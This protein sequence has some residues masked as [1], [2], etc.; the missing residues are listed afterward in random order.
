MNG[1]EMML[2]VKYVNQLDNVYENQGFAVDGGK[3]GQIVAKDSLR[4]YRQL[5]DYHYN[6]SNLRSLVWDGLDV[7]WLSS[8]ARVTDVH[9]QAL[10]HAGFA[11]A[12]LEYGLPMRVDMSQ[13]SDTIGSVLHGAHTVGRCMPDAVPSDQSAWNQIA[14]NSLMLA[15]VGVRPMMDVL[16]TMSH[17]PGN[18][19]K[20]DR[21]NVEHDAIFTTLSTGPFGIG[22]MLNYTNVSLIACATRAD[23]V[24]IKPA[25]A[26][27]RIDRF[28]NV[29]ASSSP[30]P[31][32]GPTPSP[33]PPPGPPAVV[34]C[35]DGTCEGF[36]A[37]EGMRGCAASWEGPLSMRDPPTDEACG[38]SLQNEC[39]SP[40]DACAPG[41]APC[42]S[43]E[44][45]SLTVNAFLQRVN[46]STCGS[47]SGAYAAAMSHAPI[48]AKDAHGC[49]H[50]AAEDFTC[51]VSGYGS[52]PLCCGAHCSVPSCSEALWPHH[53]RAVLHS[54]SCGQLSSTD[55][56]GVLC[57]RTNSSYNHTAAAE[58]LEAEVE[59]EVEKE[60]GAVTAG[61]GHPQQQ[62]SRESMAIPGARFEIT[63]ALSAPAGSAVVA[64][65]PRADSRAWALP[66]LD[67]ASAVWWWNILATNVGDGDGG[68]PLHTAELYPT[69]AARS[70][71][72]VASWGAQCAG[73]STASSC[74]TRWN[75][76]QPLDVTTGV[77][78]APARAYRLFRAAPVLSSGWTLVGELGKFVAVS[79][80]RL[81]VASSGS[82]G[83]VL[84]EEHFRCAEEPAVELQFEVIGAPSEEVAVHLVAPNQRVVVIELTLG[85]SGL[86]AV[87]CAEN[88]CHKSQVL[89]AWVAAEEQAKFEEALLI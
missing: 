16:W 22:D 30:T 32:P 54:G 17:Q 36:C 47:G 76:S 68:R 34:G 1:L 41:W 15:T 33:G 79:P 28:Y 75:A 58:S 38:N 87:Q 53:T 49:V 44:T 60:V 27:L 59:V 80:Q 23:G 61:N 85:T 26:A 8:D 57:C 74:F 56:T 7:V 86:A 48:E 66:D 4:F 35:A 51:K 62:P 39:A 73:G 20:M 6:H 52:E 88:A 55:V 67:D 5:F 19:Y 37:N 69:P 29:P 84:R 11:D 43:F 63:A 82:E 72:W 46:S 21:P 83:R 9:E 10:W 24:I 77:A 78:K 50:S 89:T 45:D 18:P 40:A 64:R 13:P 31:P 71:F 3:D 65:D 14:G 2:I 12:A 81:T 70:R 42:L 25:A